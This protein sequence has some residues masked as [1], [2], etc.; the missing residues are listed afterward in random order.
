MAGFSRGICMRY[1]HWARTRV[2]RLLIILLAI[3]IYFL[4]LIVD[5]LAYFPHFMSNS[6]PYWLPWMRF[7]FSA[8]VG[9]MFLAVGA[10]VWLY[11]LSFLLSLLLFDL[12]VT[13]MVTFGV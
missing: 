11:A 12:Y 13:M 3:M 2:R 4:L 10:L 5:A 8:F 7:G 6:T 9:L 1:V